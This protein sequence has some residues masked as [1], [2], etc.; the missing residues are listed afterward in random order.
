[1]KLTIAQVFGNSNSLPISLVLSLSRTISG[2]H[3]DQIPGDNDDE[4][5]ARGILYLLIFQQLGQLLRWSWGLNVLLQRSTGDDAAEEE[6]VDSDV[7][8]GRGPGANKLD[9][10]NEPLMAD[11]AIVDSEDSYSTN[12]E[13]DEIHASK[14][15]QQKKSLS[16]SHSEPELRF[17]S[18]DQ[19]PVTSRQFTSSVSSQASL[20]KSP[21]SLS[22]SGILQ[23]PA[24]GNLLSSGSNPPIEQI[25]DEE[26]NPSSDEERPQNLKTRIMGYVGS[27][28]STLA[29][30]SDK[31]VA[32]LRSAFAALPVPLQTILAR[33]FD[34]IGAFVDVI[35]QS[36]NPPLFAMATALVVASVPNLQ[37]LFFSDG[38][39]VKNS[40]T[41]AIRQSGG[42]A[43]PL[44]LVV[45][46]ANLARVSDNEPRRPPSED[47][48]I[49]TRLLIA[50]LL[51][52]MVFPTILM[53]GVLAVA[54]KYL[55]I[56]ILD[57]PIFI[58]VCFLL[59]GAPSALQLAQICQINEV[60]MGAMARILF[61]S[62]V[63]WYG[64]KL[65]IEKLDELIKLIRGRIL[66]STLIL[67]M[68]ALEVVEWATA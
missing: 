37:R 40:I 12:R 20:A 11:V 53:G 43:V 3:W 33:I 25:P 44:I 54:A 52:R 32:C 39:F 49:E 30:I 14:R 62:Y 22:S 31:T 34:G 68:C 47:D 59:A 6:H 15:H 13:N 55:N 36:M 24:K 66:P 56:S 4:V 21:P 38:T 23:T 58:I 35:W 41:S 29:K 57:D 18:G 10:E 51:S 61:H 9:G 50:S 42:V 63:I 17:G 1:M 7:E 8:R 2:L 65:L 64:P 5:G 48:K 45:L 27:C 28:K 19:T 46:G 26:N 60:Y 16:T 67:V